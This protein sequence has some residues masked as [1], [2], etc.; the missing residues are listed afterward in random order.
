MMWMVYCHPIPNTYPLKSMI[1]SQRCW[2]SW[3]HEM[4]GHHHECHVRSIGHASRGSNRCTIVTSK[5]QSEHHS[6]M[7]GWV[8]GVWV[9][10]GEEK[11]EECVMVWAAIAQTLT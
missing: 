5:A 6:H 7:R 3:W 4:P 10:G 9:S 11:I 1:Q 8:W 2:W